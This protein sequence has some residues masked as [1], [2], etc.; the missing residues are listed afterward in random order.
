MKG[1]R[2]ILSRT[3][4]GL[5]QMTSSGFLLSLAVW[6]ATYL[7]WVIW[8]ATDMINESEAAKTNR[9]KPLFHLK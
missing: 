6:L 5:W 1:T 3:D 4:G 9:L 7:I 2:L 8:H